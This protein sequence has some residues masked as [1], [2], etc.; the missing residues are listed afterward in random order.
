MTPEEKQKNEKEFLAFYELYYWR[1]HKIPTAA[2]LG[3]EFGFRIS[4]ELYA[5][6]LAKPENFTHLI[7][8]YVPLPQDI[9]PRLTPKQLAL[10][11]TITDPANRQTLSQKLKAHN[12]SPLQYSR[13]LDDPL[14]AEIL[15]EETNKLTA[16][17]RDR[18]LGAI[19]NEASAGNIQA[20]KLYLELQGEYTPKAQITDG[21]EFK[22]M[23]LK[24]LEVLKKYIDED[25]LIQVALELEKVLFGEQKVRQ[26]RRPVLS[27]AVPVNSLDNLFGIPED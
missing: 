7:Q 23:T 2:E 1:H 11:A 18:V 16:N 8:R 21:T 17:S 27:R 12:V 3:F 20:A 22:Q 9:T 6:L 14:F 19:V 24:L 25:T 13:W 26:P 5:K 15:Y 10:I 4:E